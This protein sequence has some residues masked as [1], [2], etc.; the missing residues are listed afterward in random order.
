MSNAYHDQIVTGFS[1]SLRNLSTILD[2]AE[3]YATREKFDIAN[4]LQ[5]RLYPDM[6]PCTRQVQLATDFAKGAACRLTGSESPK[7][8]E[9][10][11]SVAE[12]KT[13]L[14]NALDLLAGC[15]PAQFEG[16]ATRAI[17][18]KTPAGTFHF[19]GAQFL[20]RWAVPNFYFHCTTAYA[21]LRHQGVPLGKLDFLGPL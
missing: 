16:A 14:Q 9:S 15:T 3:A 4:L 19:T 20:L 17:E 7:W 6:F 18:V 10:E 1:H 12:L 8:G 13:R 11:K 21:L 2:R 5:A